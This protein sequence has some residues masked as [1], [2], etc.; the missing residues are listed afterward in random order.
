MSKTMTVVCTAVLEVCPPSSMALTL[1][2]FRTPVSPVAGVQKSLRFA[3]MVSFV[4]TAQS[5]A[6][7]ASFPIFKL[8]LVT[9]VMMKPTTVPSTSFS[10]PLLNKSLKVNVTAKS[11][12]PV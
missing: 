3:L 11:L 8:P 4:P 12:N 5:V 6:E 2:A 10:F 1:N 9:S 7:A